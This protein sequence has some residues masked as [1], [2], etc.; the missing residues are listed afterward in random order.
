MFK[1]IKCSK[2][3]WLDLHDHRLPILISHLLNVQEF[4][5]IPIV[6]GPTVHKY[7]G[8]TAATIHHQAVAQVWVARVCCF[9]IGHPCQVPFK[10]KSGIRVSKIKRSGFI[11][12][13][14]E[15]LPVEVV[16]ISDPA[17]RALFTG[18][19]QEENPDEAEHQADEDQ[20]SEGGC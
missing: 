9:N 14:A 6:P 13:P 19:Q 16:F 20:L 11:F 17:D 2:I 8:A 7:P 4:F 18:K 1:S 12:K 15:R 3:T 5:G 10:V